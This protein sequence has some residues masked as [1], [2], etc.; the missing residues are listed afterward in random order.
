MNNSPFLSV[1]VPVKD[2]EPAIYKSLKE[3]FEFF[4]REKISFEIIAINDGSTDNTPREMERAVKEIPEIRYLQNKVNRGKGFSLRRMVLESRGQWILLTDADLS[5]P[6]EEY[7]KF[8]R[9]MDTHDIVIASRAIK[10]AKVM[11]HQA[12]YKE[13]LGKIGNKIIRI[14]LGLPFH[15]T[16]CGFKLYRQ[17]LVRPLFEKLLLERWGFDFELL[18]LASKKKLRMI[19]LPVRWLDDGRSNVEKFAYFTTLRDVFKV[20]L[21]YHLGKY[22]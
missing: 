22:K 10:G 11:V 17:K 15:D 7:H 8:K 20:R 4:T 18:F 3:I 21:N 9:Y 12:W 6:L 2:E 19:E 1:V 5:T 13:L 16:Q 14:I